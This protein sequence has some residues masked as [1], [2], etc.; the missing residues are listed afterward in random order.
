MFLCAQSHSRS[1]YQLTCPD[2]SLSLSLSLF[3]TL[4]PLHFTHER[5]RAEAGAERTLAGVFRCRRSAR[6]PS[7]R[8]AR[9]ISL[10]SVGV[11]HT[12]PHHTTKT[13]LNISEA[14][15]LLSLSHSLTL[16]LSYSLSL[17]HSLSSHLV[18]P[19]LTFSFYMVL[20]HT[21]VTPESLS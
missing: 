13:H 16:S 15:T 2:L 19:S 3:S 6:T 20:D 21:I 17:T 12:T 1:R 8:C 18:L 7:F 4:S 11:H 9:F 5:A 10:S 14:L